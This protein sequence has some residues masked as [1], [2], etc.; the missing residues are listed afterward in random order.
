MPVPSVIGSDNLLGP[1]D[2]MAISTGER[3]RFHGEVL[4]YAGLKP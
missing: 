4:V 2:E 1:V 3:E